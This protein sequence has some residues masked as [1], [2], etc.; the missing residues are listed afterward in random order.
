MKLTEGFSTSL[1]VPKS[2]IDGH[3]ALHEKSGLKDT[4]TEENLQIVL[5]AVTGIRKAYGLPDT[6]ATAAD[7]A[8]EWDADPAYFKEMRESA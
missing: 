7:W 8:A 6:V 1:C 2:Y 3:A 4:T 5:D